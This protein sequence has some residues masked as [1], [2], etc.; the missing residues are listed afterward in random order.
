MA[1]H[2]SPRLPH[3][4]PCP[5]LGSFWGGGFDSITPLARFDGHHEHRL[6]LIEA[7]EHD[8]KADQDYRLL[9]RLGIKWA[10]EDVRWYRCELEPGRFTFTHLEPIVAAAQQHAVQVVWSWMHYGCPAFAEPLADSFPDHLA[11][12]GER[13]LQWLRARDAAAGIVAPINELSYFTWHVD[14]VGAWFP[15]ARGQGARLKAQLMA[16]HRRAYQRVKAVAPEVRVLL[17]DPFYYAVGS[18]DDPGSMA[19]AAFWRDAALEAAGH[20]TDCTDILGLNFYYDGQVE[21]SRRPSEEHYRRRTLSPLDRRRISLLDAVR[22]F[23]ERFG[24]PV[25]VT[26]TSVRADRRLPWL[27][28]LTDQAVQV[29][30]EGLPLHGL[31]WYPIM[32]VPDWGDLATDQTLRQLRLAHSGLIRLDRAA[33]GLRRSLAGNIVRAMHHHEARLQQALCGQSA[34][35]H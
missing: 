20:L 8:R 9:G 16:A 4:P 2:A 17:I 34:A 35:A 19:E 7:T 21:V 27:A 10:R 25:L 15:F 22:L 30:E 32:D 33:H 31:C 24:K 11:T 13:F 1:E 14:N 6:D 28:T 12:L 26:E 18:E 29:I 3:P 5:P 23:V